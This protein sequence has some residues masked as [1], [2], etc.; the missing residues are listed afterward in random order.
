MGPVIKWKGTSSRMPSPGVKLKPKK[1]RSLIVP[2]EIEG[3]V[4]QKS[5]EV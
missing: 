2:N 4:E 3:V 5:D 1:K